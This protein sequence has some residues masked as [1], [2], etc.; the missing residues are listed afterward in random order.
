M[1]EVSVRGRAAVPVLTTAAMTAS[2]L[3]LFLL[4]A[5]SPALVREFG[6]ERPLLGV[7]VT[8]GFGVAVVLSLAIGPAV[9]ALGPRRSIIALFATSAVALAVFALAPHYAVL[10]CAVA[11]GGVPQALAN[12]ST[13]KLIATSVEPARRPVLLGIK[14]S[15]VQLGAF[16]AGLPLA[17][18]ADGVDWRLAVGVAA[19]L[20]LVAAFGCL[21]LPQD[22]APPRRVPF[23][24]S[25]GSGGLIWRLAAFSVLLGS[26]I[27]AVNTYV[28]LYATE[29][30][31]F[32]APVAAGL[33]A[34]LGVVGIAGRIVWSRVAGR[35]LLVGL[36]AAAVLAPLLLLTG[37]P[38]LAWAAM[39]VVGG[40]AVA[41]NAISMVL[42]VAA[43]RGPELGRNSALVSAGFF[44]GFAV[45][46]PLFGLLGYDAGWVLVA[47]EFGLAAVVAWRAR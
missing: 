15:G 7:L 25:V 26:G 18:L 23:A 24:L 13:N 16:L 47:V 9:D 34:V 10:V 35:E 36:S 46:P 20:A 44:A 29:E 33:V 1:E 41:A 8:A 2:M 4:G 12:P 6:I 37:V 40:C 21:V 11:L 28:A 45:G 17:W 22:V 30:L 39:V 5:L 19:G 14:Q 43:S 38:V 32:G 3:P 42:V 31:G 27:A